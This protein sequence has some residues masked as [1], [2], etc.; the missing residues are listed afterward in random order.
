MDIINFTPVTASLGGVLIGLSAMALLLLTGNILGIS[1]ILSNLLGKPSYSWLLRLTF[2]L[3]AILGAYTAMSLGW[4]PGTIEVT[5][6]QW[7]LIAGGLLVGAGTVMGSGCTSGHGVCGVSRL[8]K[9]SLVATVVFMGLAI[10]TVYLV[11][12]VAYG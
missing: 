4:A 5:H 10:I 12:T 7:Q 6:H 3:G 11:R 9:R 8:S 2:I 1:G